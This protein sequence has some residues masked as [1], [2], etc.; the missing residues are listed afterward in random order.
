MDEKF[1]AWW[2]KNV[3]TKW[4]IVYPIV[5]FFGVEWMIKVTFIE[6]QFHG[7][8]F[9]ARFVAFIF[10]AGYVLGGRMKE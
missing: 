6:L 2:K 10:L 5:G 8:D 9:F 7:I 1:L 4:R 3:G